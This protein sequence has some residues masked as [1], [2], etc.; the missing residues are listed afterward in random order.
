MRF[1]AR[2]VD[3]ATTSS[4]SVTSTAPSRTTMA[5]GWAGLPCAAAMLAMGFNGGANVEHTQHWP[6]IASWTN[7]PWHT[8]T[9]EPPGTPTSS[10]WKV[11]PV[12]PTAPHEDENGHDLPCPCAM[13]RALSGGGVGV[14]AVLT[15]G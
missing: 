5:R 10:N 14:V 2:E 12:G 3:F 7:A 11:A 13:C 1:G 6:R 4:A 15:R 9:R 8:R